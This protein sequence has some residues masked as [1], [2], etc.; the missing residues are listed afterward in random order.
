MEASD[1]LIMQQN[2]LI[3]QGIVAF[4]FFLSCSIYFFYETIYTVDFFFFY[5]WAKENVFFYQI[6][7]IMEAIADWCM[8]SPLFDCLFTGLLWWFVPV[9]NSNLATSFASWYSR[10]FVSTVKA[11]WS[12]SWTPRFA[13]SCGA[14]SSSFSSLKYSGNFRRS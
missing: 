5:H 13:A 12:V 3:L 11:R 1:W 10:C 7:T 2:L 8:S 4:F 6:R 9:V 14:R